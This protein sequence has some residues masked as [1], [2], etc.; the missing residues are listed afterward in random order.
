MAEP[1]RIFEPEIERLLKEAAAD[2]RSMLLR[3]PRDPGQRAP[4][5]LDA[6]VSARAAGLSPVEHHILQTCRAEAGE[7]LWRWVSVALANSND[8][9]SLF[10]SMDPSRGISSKPTGTGLRDR[11]RRIQEMI[12]GE[13]SGRLASQ[14]LGIGQDPAPSLAELRHLAETS[15]RIHPTDSARITLAVIEDFAGNRRTAQEILSSLLERSR[16]RPMCALALY[17][18][19]RM[20][21]IEERSGD[22]AACYRSSAELAPHWAM[23]LTTLLISL[24]EAGDPRAAMRTALRL[25]ALGGEARAEVE[26]QREGL[27]KEIR[28]AGWSPTSEAIALAED[29]RELHGRLS[30]RLLD[31]FEPS[32]Q[33]SSVAG[34]AG[35]SSRDRTRVP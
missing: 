1:V 26:L 35:G 6:G 34:V 27:M 9:P 30:R 21:R 7:L 19:G 4:F 18:L 23:P 12:E 20:H 3:V 5:D 13:A 32:L 22:A 29:V 25:D 24:I 8:L 17:N 2:P 16:D 10:R 28:S 33:G 11:A 15:L 31:V 14:L